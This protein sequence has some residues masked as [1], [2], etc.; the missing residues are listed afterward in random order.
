MLT[1]PVLCAGS[2]TVAVPIVGSSVA[3]PNDV[4]L[5]VMEKVTVPEVTGVVPFTSVAVI[6][7]ALPA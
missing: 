3:E 1:V 7:A 6:C 5:P 2:V 4:P